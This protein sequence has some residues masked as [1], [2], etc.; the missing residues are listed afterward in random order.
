MRSKERND[1]AMEE[2]WWKK[3]VNERKNRKNKKNNEW[4]EGE[5]KRKMKVRKEGQNE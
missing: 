3:V 1:E 2:K 4:K 5:R